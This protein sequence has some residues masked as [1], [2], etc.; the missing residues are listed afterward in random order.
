MVPDSLLAKD[1]VQALLAKGFV[2]ALLA[3]GFV[4]HCLKWRCTGVVGKRFVQH[5]WLTVFVQHCWLT[6]LFSVV[7]RQVG[8]GNEGLV[9]CPGHDGVQVCGD[10]RLHRLQRL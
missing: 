10:H 6:V 2:Q 5:C 4:Q 3:N 1:F 7:D 8:F 9:D